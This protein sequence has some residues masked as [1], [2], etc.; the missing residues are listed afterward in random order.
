MVGYRSGAAPEPLHRGLPSP[1]L[2]LVVARDDGVEAAAD[3]A[4]LPSA[5]PNRLVLGGL[6]LT[7]SWVRQRPGQSGVQLAVHPL[8]ARSLL[9]V[10]AAELDVTAFA[11]APVL[12]RAGERLA[13][14]LGETEGWPEAFALL[15]RHLRRHRRPVAVRPE[16]RHAW[17]LLE[18]SGGLIQVGDLAAAVGL[19][20]RH[21]GTLFAREV[22]RSPKQV[23]QLVRFAR[24]STALAAQ[25]RRGHVDLAVLAAACGYCDQSHLTREFTR[26]AGSPPTRWLAAEFRNIQDGGLPGDAP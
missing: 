19:T 24:A 1:R 17:Y 13:D 8:A 6:H 7:A 22:G 11:G 15:T 9:G 20:S 10:P 3:A 5:R 23:G 26:F 16:L 12:G 4:A 2:T 18:R 21:L 14:Q 25:A